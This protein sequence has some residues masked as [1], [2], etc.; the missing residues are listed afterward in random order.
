M[1]KLLLLAAVAGGLAVVNA[2]IDV[3]RQ[4]SCQPECWCQ[5]P[6]LRHFRWVFPIGHKDVS[7]D[8]KQETESA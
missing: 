5:R 4:C 2:R 8:W 6:G 3:T 7:S 1:K